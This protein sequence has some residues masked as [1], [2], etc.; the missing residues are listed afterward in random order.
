MTEREVFEELHA[1]LLEADLFIESLTTEGRER[2]LTDIDGMLMGA[3]LEVRRVTDTVSH[4]SPKL[5]EVRQN[6][7]ACANAIQAGAASIET[8][9]T[10]QMES[11]IADID[12]QS[13]QV[14]NTLARAIEQL[15]PVLDIANDRLSALLQTLDRGNQRLKAVAQD[16]SATLSKQRA[17]ID[18]DV[19]NVARTQMAD[20]NKR[21]AAAREK[22]AEIFQVAQED[23]L[24]SAKEAVEEVST[25]ATEAIVTGVEEIIDDAVAPVIEELRD[26]IDETVEELI[27][28]LMNLVTDSEEE[29]GEI[30]EI[31]D[32]VD[33]LVEP[34][35]SNV[36]ILSSVA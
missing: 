30:T 6:L 32:S 1:R 35:L 17:L 14:V 31:T 24:T 26:L 12:R 27:D 15:G 34:L 16:Y 19:F 21:I 11:L 29:N 20:C 3:V 28:V 33:P 18:K 4:L 23:L 25:E 10:T 5:P 7:S 8:L 22:V 2:I 13:E 9:R 36:E